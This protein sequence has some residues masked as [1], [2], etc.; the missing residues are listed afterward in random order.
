MATHKARKGALTSAKKPAAVGSPKPGVDRSLVYTS[1]RFGAYFIVMSALVLAVLPYSFI[2]WLQLITTDGA[3]ALM[4]LAGLPIAREGILI[5]LPQATLQIDLGCTA[6]VIVGVYASLVL[7][8]QATAV[9]RLVGIVTGT[10]F[11]LLINQ[12][13]LLATGLA[14]VY[15]PNAFALLHDYLYQVAMVAVVL[16]AWAVW[17]RWLPSRRDSD[18]EPSDRTRKGA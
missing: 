4:A 16:V 9:E 1:L 8:Y 3:A 11:I 2:E 15:T 6:I 10:A 14:L 5:H 17:L 12:V 18:P 13:R 7:A